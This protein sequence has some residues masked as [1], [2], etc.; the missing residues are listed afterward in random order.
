MKNIGK[1][2]MGI[3]LFVMGILFDR[4]WMK[5]IISD[6]EHEIYSLNEARSREQV[7]INRYAD[8]LDIMIGLRKISLGS[9]L[10]NR[11]YTKVAIYGMGEL[12]EALADELLDA[13][14]EI[15]YAI[16][17]KKG[18]QKYKAIPIV[19]PDAELEP[20]HC[21]IVSTV[22]NFQEVQVCLEKKGIF[23]SVALYDMLKEARKNEMGKQG[24]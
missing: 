13:G 21:I 15:R 6:Y 2:L 16:D 19:N 8:K 4:H 18:G 20:V 12:G 1:K 14:M 10:I 24:T 5:K 23:E 11:G 17:K 7:T 9:Y 22:R 3:S